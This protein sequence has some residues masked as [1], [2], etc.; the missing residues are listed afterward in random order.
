MRYLV[1]FSLLENQHVSRQKPKNHC[2]LR[3][4]SLENKASQYVP[5]ILAVLLLRTTV[6][7]AI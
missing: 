6:L 4:I 3:Y 5:A 1:V 2:V 7:P